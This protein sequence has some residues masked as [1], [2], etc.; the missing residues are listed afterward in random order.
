MTVAESHSL[1]GAARRQLSSRSRSS[2][3]LITCVRALVTGEASR[4]RLTESFIR[5]NTRNDNR[6]AS[7][8]SRCQPCFGL[9]YDKKRSGGG[10]SSGRSLWILP[11]Q[12]GSTRHAA[13]ENP[14]WLT[15]KDTPPVPTAGL[16]RG[17]DGAELFPQGRSSLSHPAS[18]RLQNEALILSFLIEFL[19]PGKGDRHAHLQRG[20][21]G[22][23]EELRGW[24]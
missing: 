4:R 23:S 5:S 1:R 14:E 12:A 11:S 20:P 2:S 15:S 6:P 7:R 24:E 18:L 8:Y 19:T 10:Q 13:F 9:K 16:G 21:G 17:E 3:E 22:G